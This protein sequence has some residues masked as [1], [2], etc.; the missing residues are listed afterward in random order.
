VLDDLISALYRQNININN[1]TDI[2]TIT[3]TEDNFKDAL[4]EAKKMRDAGR[5]VVLKCK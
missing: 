3:Y 2:T 4:A 5:N 1:E